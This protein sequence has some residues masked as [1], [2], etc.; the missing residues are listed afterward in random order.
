M[1][2]NPVMI[3][4]GQELGE[5]GMDEEGFSG[6]DGRTSIFDYWSIETIRKWRNNDKFDGE[7]LT[8]KQKQL[9]S[10]YSKLLNLCNQEKAIYQGQF[11]DLMYVNFG[12]PDFNVHKQYVFFR[13][14][15]NE[16]LLIIANFDK[17]SS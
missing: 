6:K 17:Q 4:F 13:K 5:H 3:Y 1:N 2:T 7:F 14:Q 8:N 11:F 16:L 9:Q 15:D 10:F 12:K